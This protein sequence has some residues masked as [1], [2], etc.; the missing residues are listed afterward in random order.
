[1]VSFC[2]H[3][4]PEGFGISFR[5]LICLFPSDKFEKEKNKK[6]K[7]KKKTKI[8]LTDLPFSKMGLLCLFAI[9]VLL[10]VALLKNQNAFGED[11][12]KK[13]DHIIQKL[14]TA[15]SMPKRTN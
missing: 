2:W 4:K 1:M 15:S 10:S 8:D 14:D 6:T 11:E 3:P 7:E 5:V 13:F 9:E 12:Y